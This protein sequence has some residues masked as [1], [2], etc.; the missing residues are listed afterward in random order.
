MIYKKCNAWKNMLILI[1]VF[2]LKEKTSTWICEEKE[3]N[4]DKRVGDFE[5]VFEK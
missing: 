1:L 5:N 4:N 3:K 2:V